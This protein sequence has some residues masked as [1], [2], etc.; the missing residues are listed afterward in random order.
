M[1]IFEILGRQILQIDKV[2]TCASLSTGTLVPP[3]ETLLARAQFAART[4]THESSGERVNSAHVRHVPIRPHNILLRVA[5]CPEHQSSR[6]ASRVDQTV[7]GA[8]RDAYLDRHSPAPRITSAHDRSTARWLSKAGETNHAWSAPRNARPYLTPM[9]MIASNPEAAAH[10]AVAVV[11]PIGRH[12][13]VSATDYSDVQGQSRSPLPRPDNPLILLRDRDGTNPPPELRERPGAVTLAASLNFFP[14]GRSGVS[15][16]AIGISRARSPASPREIPTDAVSPASFTNAVVPTPPPIYTLPTRTHPPILH[17]APASILH[18]NHRRD[19]TTTSHQGTTI[20]SPRMELL[21]M[22]P[23]EAIALRVYSLPAAVAAAG[24]LYYAWLVAALA[25][26]VGLWR[27]RAIGASKSGAAG[28]R[29]G[30]AVVDTKPQAQAPPPSPAFEEPPRPADEPAAAS[31]SASEPSTPSKVRFTAYYGVSGADDQDGVVDGVRRCADEDDDD[32]EATEAVL[33]RTA[34][35]PAERRRA[36]APWEEREM[37]VR[38]RGDLGWYRHI[39]MAA[40]DGS[41]VRLWDGELTAA[42]PR[43]RRRRAGLELQEFGSNSA[44]DLA[45]LR[46]PAPNSELF[47]SDACLRRRPSPPPPVNAL[48]PSSLCSCVSRQPPPHLSPRSRETGADQGGRRQPPPPSHPPPAP[49][50]P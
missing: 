26:A 6:A 10:G 42:S 20:A 2:T 48:R 3:Q 40:L 45:A 15:H 5:V 30:S 19:L 9:V 14:A 39:D 37:A 13:V 29:R 50:A 31:S 23:A 38:R 18:P 41:V 28:V 36:S 11:E 12:R 35:A 33:R 7:P 1:S 22:V 34:S 16:S 47:A 25:A 8:S 27:I 32:G 17:T 24:S 4:R 46:A 21:D 49:S 44:G 43:A